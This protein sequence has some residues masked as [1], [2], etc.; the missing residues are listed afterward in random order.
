MTASIS[1]LLLFFET[2]PYPLLW[3]KWLCIYLLFHQHGWKRWLQ[4]RTSEQN[5]TAAFCSSVTLTFAQWFLC[6]ILTQNIVISSI[7]WCLVTLVYAQKP[8]CT[9]FLWF[10]GGN[11]N[12]PNFVGKRTTKIL[13]LFPFILFPFILEMLVQFRIDKRATLGGHHQ[14]A[15]L[16]HHHHHNHQ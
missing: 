15:H 14:Q 5:P 13:F 10:F 8:H 11:P 4:C 12:N 3:C 9:T 1:S 6:K 16:H 7:V 2:L